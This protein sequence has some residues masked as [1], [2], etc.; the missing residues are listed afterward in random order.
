MKHLFLQYY[1]SYGRKKMN[2]TFLLSK[3]RNVHFGQ[4]TL[5]RFLKYCWTQLQNSDGWICPF[6]SDVHRRLHCSRLSAKVYFI[7]R[8]Y[9]FW[10]YQFLLCLNF[11]LGS[12]CF[13]I[14]F[15][16]EFTTFLIAIFCGPSGNTLSKQWR[17][18][19]AFHNLAKR[20][21]H[22]SLL[23]QSVFL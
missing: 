15:H 6:I 4:E 18:L 12:K 7:R 9:H 8:H 13:L 14:F 5:R 23:K 16:Y 19:L 1:T 3:Q 21:F 2:S 17:T 22:L 20:N 11:S 10:C